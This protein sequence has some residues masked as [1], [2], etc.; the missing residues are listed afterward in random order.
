MNKMSGQFERCDE[1]AMAAFK[2]RLIDPRR[3]SR[4]EARKFI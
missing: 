1:I 3:I 2:T 4:L